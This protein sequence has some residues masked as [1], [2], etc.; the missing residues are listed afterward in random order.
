MKVKIELEIDMSTG[1]YDVR[2]HNLSNPGDVV[3]A[4]KVCKVAS[5]VIE[6][7]QAGYAK[8]TRVVE[9]PSNLSSW[10]IL[11]KAKPN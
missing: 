3:D 9:E 5:R 4:T 1:T 11:D 6:N 2:F 8:A 7:I 10:S